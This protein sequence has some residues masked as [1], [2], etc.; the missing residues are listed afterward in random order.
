M[1]TNADFKFA[2]RMLHYNTNLLS[3]RRRNFTSIILGMILHTNQAPT[4]TSP[5]PFILKPLLKPFSETSDIWKQNLV[6]TTCMNFLVVVVILEESVSHISWDRAVNCSATSEF[7]G[8][9]VFF[10][11]KLMGQ[12][13]FLIFAP[14]E[15][16]NI[17]SKIVKWLT[18]SKKRTG[19]GV[20]ARSNSSL[21][22]TNVPCVTAHL[23][24]LVCVLRL[25]FVKHEYVSVLYIMT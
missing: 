11:Y 4:F 12:E 10:L 25:L 15:S 23:W 18:D 6:Y 5:P 7:F 13:Y 17:V 16:N 24:L 1:S 3:W 14:L 22:P 20:Q 9:T 8:L 2:A 19:W 21:S